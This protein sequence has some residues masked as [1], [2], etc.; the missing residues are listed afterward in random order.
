MLWVEN[1]LYLGKTNFALA[2]I[3]CLTIAVTTT[4]DL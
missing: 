2:W 1:T 4:Q 3:P